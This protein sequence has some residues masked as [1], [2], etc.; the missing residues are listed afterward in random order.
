MWSLV[1]SGA[2]QATAEKLDTQTYKKLVS[3]EELSSRHS[4]VLARFRS[5]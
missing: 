5:C 2:S 3:D 4:W 1:S